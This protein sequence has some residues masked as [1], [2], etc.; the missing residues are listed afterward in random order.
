MEE[1]GGKLE[2]TYV[3]EALWFTNKNG[4]M[5]PEYVHN[6]HTDIFSN[7]QTWEPSIA[8]GKAMGAL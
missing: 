5:I 1:I 3:Q 7:K 6:T 8:R 4:G 2:N